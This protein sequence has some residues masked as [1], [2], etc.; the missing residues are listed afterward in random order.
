MSNCN[1]N[2]NP[3]QH[4]GTSQAER[5]LPGLQAGYVQVNEKEYA[6][7]II[8]AAEFASY[9]KYYDASNSDAGTWQVFFT[10]DISALLGTMAVQD[11]DGYRRQI[12]ERFDYI[13]DDANAA[14][15]NAIKRKLHELFSVLFSL[16]KALDMYLQR[17][18]D[19]DPEAGNFIPLKAT[20]Q[21]SIE[22]RLAP[23]LQRLIAYHK[24][25][26]AQTLLQP[27]DFTGWKVLSTQVAAA[28]T[29]ITNGLSK[30][31][32][33]NGAADWNTYVSGIVADASILGNTA[34][35]EY[36]RDQSCREP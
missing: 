16:A 11:I 34:W 27:G 26:T 20:L 17:L 4:N 2:K 30:Y 21:N 35:I 23:A 28:E 1:D 13:K 9:L 6:D 22:T 12:K 7:W 15:I 33:R 32:W 8:F 3:L 19:N 36:R 24:A 5:L 18:P 14:D 29:I 25:A 10:S 31:W